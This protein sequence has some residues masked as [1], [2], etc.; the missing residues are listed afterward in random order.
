[1]GD[2]RVDATRRIAAPAH[3]IFAI[4]SSPEGHV[5]IDGS[6][7]LVAAPDNKPVTGVG[8]TFDIDM[9]RRPLGDIPTMAEYTVRNRVTRFEPDRLFEWEVGGV[10]RP[11]VG[12]VYGWLIE[13]VSN[14]ECD[15]TNYCDWSG[16]SAE[17]LETSKDR[18]PIVPM[19]LLDRS[20]EKLEQLVTKD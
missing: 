11:A 17:M 10:E 13:P 5:Q 1:M 7:M 16:L 6:G 14:T 12:H 4:V 15:V 19:Q 8:D 3:A 2:L 20:V 9:D 18:W